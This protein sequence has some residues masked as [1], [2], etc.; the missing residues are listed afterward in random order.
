M[1]GASKTTSPKPPSQRRL[2]RPAT[3]IMMPLVAGG[4]KQEINAAWAR[5]PSHPTEHVLFLSNHPVPASLQPPRAP[6]WLCS[7]FSDLRYEQCLRHRSCRLAFL[8]HLS[9]SSACSCNTCR[10]HY[11]RFP[12][13]IPLGTSRRCG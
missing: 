13:H 7:F 5:T 1:R 12:L 11:A 2:Y 4:G 6:P 9:S 8:S 3:G 10:I